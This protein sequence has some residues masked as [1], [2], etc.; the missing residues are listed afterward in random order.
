VRLV[1]LRLENLRAF[2]SLDLELAPSWNVF[3]GP[4]GAGKTTLLEAAYL[5][6]HA[7]SFRA[8]PREAL[9][10]HGTPGFSIFGRVERADAT[11]GLGLARVSGE[12]EARVDGMRV[13][14]SDLLREIAV[15]CFEP[16]SHEL[17]SG[18]ADVRRRFLDWGV[19][20]VEHDFL[21]LW[22][23]YQ[24]ALRQRNALL[25]AGTE[26]SSLEPWDRELARSGAPLAAMR[27]RYAAQ[28][29]PIVAARLGEIV[30]ELGLAR[31]QLSRGWRDE[32]DAL[33]KLAASRADD[34][35]RGFT[36]QGPHRADWSIAFERAP[37]REHL[38]RGQ[39][40]LCALG[41]VLAQAELFAERRG[42]WP[43]VCIDDL[44][45]ELDAAHQERLVRTLADTAAQILVTGTHWSAA[46]ERLV[47]PP[48]KFHVEP[49]GVVQML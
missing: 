20:H 29:G 5:L 27:E 25:R 15:V 40:K 23:N 39:E 14:V 46:F 28:L 8:A 47:E 44:A 33:E 12:L 37:R 21:L 24:R 16:G 26:G 41:C 42:E 19:F 36:T 10:R 7:R 13:P 3:F 34:V 31:F 11:L 45:S 43:I 35:R 38:S 6:S 30:A 2:Q 49:E 9:V 17:I 22:R 18:S 4:N 1:R 48:A 32:A